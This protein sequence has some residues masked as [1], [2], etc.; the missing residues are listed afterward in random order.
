MVAMW[1]ATTRYIP[2]AG[3]HSSTS[4]EPIDEPQVLALDR[5]TRG[6]LGRTA[7]Q[8]V[9][10]LLGIITLATALGEGAANDWL[11]LMLVDNQGGACGGWCADVRGFQRNDGYRPVYWWRCHPALRHFISGERTN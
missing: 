4:S 2:D 9:E 6:Q 11:A 10:I 5:S 3:L 7:L 8:P 1:L